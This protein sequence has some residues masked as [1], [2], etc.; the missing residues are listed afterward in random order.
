MIPAPVKALLEGRFRRPSAPVPGEDQDS[1]PSIDTTELQKAAQWAGI[2]NTRN[3]TLE[4]VEQ[5]RLQLW[6]IAVIILFAIAAALAI[7]LSPDKPHL[8]AWITPAMVQISSLILVILFG[9]YALEKELCLRRLT[10]LLL[11]ERI[12][13]NSL[14][15]RV[16]EFNILLEAGKSMNL[17]LNLTDVLK[18]ITRCTR[19]LLNARGTK[20]M[21]SM[22]DQEFRT[23][24]EVGKSSS[25]DEFVAQLVRVKKQAALSKAQDRGPKSGSDLMCVP[26]IHREEFFGVIVVTSSHGRRYTQHDLRALSL[27]GEQAASAVANAK[28]YEEQR[29]FAF[30]SS[31][32]ASHDGLTRLPSRNFFLESLKNLIRDRKQSGEPFAMLF[33]DMD[34]FKRIN[35]GLG[36]AAGDAVLMECGIRIRRAIRHKDLAARFGGDE[37]V[38]LAPHADS[39]KSAI[40]LAN[41][42]VQSVATTIQV[43]SREV[44]LA[45]SIGI[46]MWNPDI[47]AETFIGNAD[48][49]AQKAKSQVGSIVVYNES[50]RS[51][52]L[53]DIKLELSLKQALDKSLLADYYQPIVTLDGTDSYAGIE[54]LVRWCPPGEEPVPARSFIATAHR[55]GLLPDMDKWV[56]DKACE[57][58]KRL[59]G[60]GNGKPCPVHVNV[61]PSH[62]RSS[63]LIRRFEQALEHHDLAPERLVLE[64]TEYAVVDDSASVRNTLKSLKKLGLQLALD[65][66]GV[67]FSSLSYLTRLPI[68]IL[69]VDQSFVAGL[70]DSTQESLL[71]ETIMK[72]GDLLN[73]KVIAE[74]IETEYQMKAL[75]NLGCSYGQGNY[76]AS[77]MV[78]DDVLSH[79]SVN[80]EWNRE[81]DETVPTG[82]VDMVVRE[83]G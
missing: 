36:H 21:L 49:A 6:V 72:M 23:V 63:G 17:E 28:F 31:F 73:L 34:R 2:S 41:R 40:E 16:R 37:F 33:I 79:A 38:V 25:S 8:P 67:G 27:F 3:L 18:T 52:A 42:I 9:G 50:M 43:S 45:C 12:L 51:R 54:A 65:D 55:T 22:G 75:R 39:R 20:I 14:L 77:P 59:A 53:D 29:L 69:K 5:R 11:S 60:A 19:E 44:R 13:T 71:I 4:A 62:L 56:L 47:D 82:G 68:D 66:F 10:S 70:G 64:I 58:G 76:L 83:S 80:N 57:T 7:V 35:D 81:T 30:R 32:Q 74:G 26:L 1:S 46:A 48:M 61:H 15:T 78:A 24:T